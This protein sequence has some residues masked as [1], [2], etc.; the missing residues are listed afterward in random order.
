MQFYPSQWRDVLEEAKWKFRLWL[1]TECPFPDRKIHF[2]K[3]EDC[4]EEALTEHWEN[5]GGVEPGT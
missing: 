4:I 2:K 3:A 1:L 5:G